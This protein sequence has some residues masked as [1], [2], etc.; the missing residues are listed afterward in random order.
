MTT[1][2][3]EPNRDEQPAGPDGDPPRIRRVERNGGGDLVLHLHGSDEPVVGVVLARCFPWALPESYISVRSGDGHEIVLLKTLD[4]LDPISREIVEA[5]LRNKIFNPK[6]LRILEYKHEFGISSITAETDRGRA[7]F[8]FRGRDDV[9]FLSAT[10]LL[11]RDA[12]GNTYELPDTRLLDPASQKHLN[13]N[14]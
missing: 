14:L 13:R 12:D 8:Q 3:D 5:E 6:I 9:R 10:R 7:V 4:E 1:V 2:Q 11:F